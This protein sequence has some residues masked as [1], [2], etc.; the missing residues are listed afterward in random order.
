MA[1]SDK[2][3]PVHTFQFINQIRLCMARENNTA[4]RVGI[5]VQMTTR[6][7]IDIYSYVQRFRSDD[8]DNHDG[9]LTSNWHV[10]NYFVA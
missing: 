7:R 9:A 10:T 2:S 4:K 5:L 3:V 1:D 8:N 6:K